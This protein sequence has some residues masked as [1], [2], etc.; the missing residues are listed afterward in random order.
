MTA[1]P[2]SIRRQS[3]GLGFGVKQKPLCKCKFS[4]MVR[5]SINY[6]IMLQT[7]FSLII[8]S[9]YIHA[10]TLTHLSTFAH[11]YGFLCPR[12]GILT[13]VLFLPPHSRSFHQNGKLIQ[14]AFISHS[15]EVLGVGTDWNWITTARAVCIVQSPNSWS[16]CR[17]L[18]LQLQPVHIRIHNGYICWKIIHLWPERGPF[19]PFPEN[20]IENGSSRKG[21]WEVF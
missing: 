20:G 14:H 6:Q 3:R 7:G 11:L 5:F 10:Y 4:Q 8:H 15:L 19:L 16:G 18:L 2:F 21:K 13:L 17:M 12:A 9:S 1:I